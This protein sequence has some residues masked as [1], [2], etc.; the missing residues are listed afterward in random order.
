MVIERNETETIIR[1]NKYPQMF[2]AA[3]LLFQ[4]DLKYYNR[5]KRTPQFFSL[6]DFREIYEDKRKWDVEDIICGLP[7]N[8]KKLALFRTSSL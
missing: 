2:L 7:D 1:N 8:Q 6:L 3:D 5:T 4:A